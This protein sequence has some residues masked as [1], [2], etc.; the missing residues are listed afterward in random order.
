[1][2]S[3]KVKIDELVEKINRHNRAY[4]EKDN[5]EISDYEYDEMMKA[6]QALEQEYPQLMNKNS[7]TQRVGGAPLDVF[8]K[9]NHVEQMLSLDNAYDVLD[10]MNFEKRLKKEL[11]ESIEYVVEYKMDGLSLA[12]EYAN[13]ELQ[14]AATRGD[15]LVGE[16]VTL[17]AKTIKS[18]PVSIDAYENILVRG[19]VF[20]YKKAFT[21]LNQV[22]EAQGKPLFANPRNAAAGS[23]RQLDS[24]IAA[25]RPLDFFAF[26]FILGAEAMG[27]S[28][29]MQAFQK[30]ETLG[31]STPPLFHAHSME[32]VIEYCEQ[33]MLKRHE[34][35]YEIDGLVVKVNDFKQREKLG[36]TQKSPRWAIAYKFPA[37][38]AVTVIE[39]IQ[40]QVGRTGVLTPLA[41]LDPVTVAGSKISKAT[42]HNQDYID[43]KDIRIGDYVW[44]HKA[45][46][47]IPAVVK[48]D[49][50]KR[51]LGAKAFHLPTTCPVCGSQA[52]RKESEVALRC[53]NETCPAKLRR[54]LMHFVSRS[55]MNI[56]GLGPAVIDLI[57]DKGWV[58]TLPDLYELDRYREELIQQPGMGEKSVDK[59]LNAIQESLKSPLHRLITGLGIPLVGSKASQ[60]IARKFKSIDAVMNAGEEELMS[61]EG[62]GSKMAAHVKAY[63]ETEP[64][65]LMVE[66][67][68]A[69]GMSCPAEDVTRKEDSFFTGKTV[70]ITGK[71]EHYSRDEMKLKLEHLGAKVTGSV[72]PKTDYLIAGEKAGSKLEKAK[73]LGLRVLNEADFMDKIDKA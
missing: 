64:V 60:L 66:R 42:L 22:Q 69:L 41:I 59:L 25:S 20:M 46:D 70:V 19:E 68:S 37:E 54:L 14:Q 52:E 50:G 35:P 71:F 15:G 13:G 47:V 62:V 57:L 6:L 72:S 58:E 38:L 63:F 12:V 7:P 21:Q 2:E 9:V 16:N 32:K 23:L 40:V 65:R 53:T 10:L 24:K 11:K 73:S 44:I 33:M 30:L 34:L 18:M 17:N 45:G 31:F 29:Q 49:I 27:L 43:Q 8:E 5:P 28:N 4:Y 39:D 55:A 3:I 36:R 56:E 26:D 51:P 67:F 48:V 1:M 61:I